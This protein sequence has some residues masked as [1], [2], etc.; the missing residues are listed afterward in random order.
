MSPAGREFETTGLTHPW[1]RSISVAFVPG[2]T[3]P[4]LTSFT[5]CLLHYFHL[6]G[7]R[8]DT[9]P[10]ASTDVILTTARFGDVV[11][12]R[13]A[14]LFSMGRRFGLN[15]S[16]TVF[17]L[18]HITPT[19]FEHVLTHLAT[20][21]AK[22]S[23]DVKDYAFPGL[24]PE[25]DRVLHE[26]G[27]RGGPLLSLVRVVQAQ[28]KSI[29]VVLIVGD[30]RPLE[31]YH[32]DLVGAHPRTG[33]DNEEFFYRD[34]VLRIVTAVSTREVT[35]HDVRGEPIP[36]SQWQTLSTPVAMRAAGRQL[37]ERSFFTETV[38]IADLVRVPA[39]SEAVANQ[40]S[41]GCFASWDTTLGALIATV[42]G[43]VRPVDKGNIC[44]DQLAVI[45]GI[46]PDGRGVFV[47]HVEGKENAPPSS[48]AVEMME[49]DQALPTIA[50][51][52]SHGQ[53]PI[54]R[55]KLHGHRGVAAYDPRRV[56][57]APLDPRYHHYLVGCA[58]EAQAEGVKQAFARSEA[59]QNPRDPRR[60]VFT[61]LPGHGIIIVEKWVDGKAP[62]Q[63][64]CEYM[65]EGYLDIK[66]PVPQG[67]LQYFPSSDGRMVGRVL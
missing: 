25:A 66:N 4:L 49:M 55:S 5:N 22:E 27:R 19:S 67:P 35:Q 10:D 3:T 2:P 33:A 46:R 57:Y 40:Y 12:W 54:V 65:D 18:I 17:T 13:Q 31:A 58:T 36:Y 50:L 9:A 48:E 32:F 39:V 41:E 38:R 24:A 16:P 61:V 64:I 29:R 20:V 26:Q 23:R 43:S 7:H 44:D 62:F 53:V 56:E 30:E 8:T 59:L 37:R 45:T 1:L 34:I 14:L 11:S 6:L 63:V 28:A 52:P 15:H 21:L 60:V 47:R 42:T 51:G